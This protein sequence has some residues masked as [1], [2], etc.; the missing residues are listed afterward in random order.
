MKV[1]YPNKPI[2]PHNTKVQLQFNTTIDTTSQPPTNLAI[3]S[4]FIDNTPH[5][6]FHHL[7]QLWGYPSSYHL[8][9]KL[10]KKSPI[11]KHDILQSD[12]ALTNELLQSR[13]IDSRKSHFYINLNTIYLVIENKEI[14]LIDNTITPA[15]SANTESVSVD[16]HSTATDPALTR[17]SNDGDISVLKH[18]KLEKV[19]IGQVFP[20]YGLDDFPATHANFNCLTS[21][22]K[23]NF[24]KAKN[25]WKFVPNNKLSFEDRELVLNDN[26]EINNANLD[27]SVKAKKQNSNVDP[28]S[29]DLTESVIP[30][31][32]YVQEFNVNHL[33]KVPNYYVS[34]TSQPTSQLR[35]SSST[36]ST[37]VNIKTSKNIQQLVNNNDPEAI[38]LSKYF[39]TKTFRGPGSGNYKDGALMNR[40]NRIPLTNDIV[41]KRHKVSKDIKLTRK[42]RASQNMKG[43]TH[44][45]YNKYMVDHLLKQQ[46]ENLEDYQN[47]EMLHNNLLFNLLLNTYRGLSK[48][49]WKSY[50]DFKMVDYEQI[51]AVKV[52]KLEI[53]MKEKNKQEILNWKQRE[54]ERTDKD[55]KEMERIQRMNYERQQIKM[56]KKR[57]LQSQQPSAHTA[58]KLQELESKYAP[59]QFKPSRP[60]PPPKQVETMNLDIANKFTLPTAYL[61]IMNNIPIELRKRGD[62]PSIKGPISYI[63]NYPDLANPLI[64]NRIEIIKLPNL[65]EIG[66]DNLRKYKSILD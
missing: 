59:L 36:T 23:L 15:S 6:L 65:N 32:G 48:A 31:Q 8:I 13:L 63:T 1:T 58:Q 7:A 2:T 11:L 56:E 51:H 21:L 39:Y 49:T 20:Q 34:L 10:I 52:Q 26:L 44:E 35:L 43:L 3:P 29:I 4:F 66:W 60:I 38:N 22:S 42:N 40:I 41:T 16:I 62:N 33:C 24:Y 46:R 25:I 61:E 54:V 57:Q 47:M 27:K 45:F 14:F 55:M 53:D 9:S 28:N 30:G 19:T 12:K 17:D 37:N 18:E 50:F 64:L 5:V